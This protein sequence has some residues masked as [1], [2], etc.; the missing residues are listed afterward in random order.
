MEKGVKIF[1]PRST[2][3]KTEMM[4]TKLAGFVQQDTV[5]RGFSRA[6]FGGFSYLYFTDYK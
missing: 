5:P 2:T 3:S 6:T 1:I 4:R